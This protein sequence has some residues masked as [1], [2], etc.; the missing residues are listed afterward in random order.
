MRTTKLGVTILSVAIVLSGGCAK[1]RSAPDIT[2][3]AESFTLEIRDSS[4]KTI[5][6]GRLSL[7]TDIAGRADFG[8]SCKIQVSEVPEKPYSQNDYAIRCLSQNNGVLS[9]S[10]RNGVVRIALHPLVWDN[11]VYL[12]GKLD[13]HSFKGKC[14]YQSYAGYM[15]FGAFEAGIETKDTP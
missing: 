3:T 4:G 15:E 12:E 5:A 2:A 7:P 6:S 1:P 13:E 10:V 11:T 8:G 9:G 14:F